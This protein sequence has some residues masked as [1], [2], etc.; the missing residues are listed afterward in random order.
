MALDP[1]LTKIISQKM[2]EIEEERGK[3]ATSSTPQGSEPEDETTRQEEKETQ[4]ES[5]ASK[6]DD[7]SAKADTNSTTETNTPTD[8]ETKFVESMKLD[9]VMKF[10][11]GEW[12]YKPEGT[13]TVYKGARVSEVLEQVAKGIVE[14][15]ATIGKLKTPEDRKPLR[16]TQSPRETEADG[17]TLP[18]PDPQKIQRQVIEEELRKRDLDP[19]YLQ[20]TDKQWQELRD[21][22]QEYEAFELRRDVKEFFK[23]VRER[24]QEL[25]R[26]ESVDYANDQLLG[27]ESD[28]LEGVLVDLGV[29]IDDQKFSEIC[30]TVLADKASYTKEGVL[31]PGVLT[32]AVLKE[33][34]PNLTKTAQTAIQKTVE[35]TKKNIPAGAKTETKTSASIPAN[36]KGE[37]KTMAQAKDR[38]VADFISGAWKK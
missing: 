4:S 5:S 34:K 23:T 19:K 32:K 31:K 38:A 28:E 35:A 3:S 21:N 27:H 1:E 18:L 30:D 10:A 7:D 15:D 24:S 8:D 14:K 36:V 33:L 17:T 13:T 29:T 6:E 9:G 2:Q 20:Y 16:V 25:Y 37:P 11:D 26:Q 12:V 22:G